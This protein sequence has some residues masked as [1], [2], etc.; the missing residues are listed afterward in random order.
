[1]VPLLLGAL[2]AA[3]AAAHGVLGGWLRGG[4]ARGGWLVRSLPLAARAPPHLQ[5]A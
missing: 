2:A 4:L 5:S 1:V 3:V